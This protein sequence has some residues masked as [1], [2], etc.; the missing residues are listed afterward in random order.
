PT[1]KVT[2]LGAYYRLTVSGSG[3]WSLSLPSAMGI[4][5][6]TSG[7]GSGF[8][9]LTVLPNLS[10]I[11]DRDISLAF[12]SGNTTNVITISQF[13][14]L[15]SYFSPSV[16]TVGH[17]SGMVIVSLIGTN[18]SKTSLLNTNNDLVINTIDSIQ[19]YYLLL[20]IEYPTNNT[21]LTNVYTVS[22]NNLDGSQSLFTL[23]Q[24]NNTTLNIENSENSTNSMITIHPNP[25]SEILNVISLFESAE[26]RFVDI[27]GNIIHTCTVKKGLNT[28]NL[29]K[30]KPGYYTIENNMG[31]NFNKLIRK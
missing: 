13:G 9:N 11:L 27:I 18:L 26:L 20:S 8:I 25:A 12:T 15:P 10:N 17:E 24:N 4:A 14:Y 16:L 1:S 19:G 7:T 22:S 31:V 23:L 3:M 21:S 30:L 5:S 6:P 29:E 28:I 2:A